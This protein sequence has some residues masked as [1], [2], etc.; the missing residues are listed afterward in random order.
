[1]IMLMGKGEEGEGGVGI[2]ALVHALPP[3]PIVSVGA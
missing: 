2:Q 3:G 1:M